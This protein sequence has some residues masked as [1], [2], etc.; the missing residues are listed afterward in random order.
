MAEWHV[1]ASLSLL[2][3]LQK[4]MMSLGLL[5]GSLLCAWTVYTGRLT[6]GDYVLFVSYVEQLYAPL[7]MLGM[8]YRSTPCLPPTTTATT[9]L[10]LSL[11]SCNSHYH[12]ATLT[13]LL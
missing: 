12:S 6:V 2:N 7:N 11:L 13:S 10:L 4:T 1:T 5:G 9:I 3:F 8:Y